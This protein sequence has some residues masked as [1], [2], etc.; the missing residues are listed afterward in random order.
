MEPLAR[1]QRATRK[2]VACEREWRAAIW[3]AVSDG[4]TLRDVAAAAGVSH[5]RVLQISRE[6][7]DTPAPGTP[8]AANTS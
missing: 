1:V 5:V 6:P 2:R 3:Q 8:H 4:H 7:H